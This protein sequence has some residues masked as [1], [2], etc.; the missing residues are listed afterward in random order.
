[1]NTNTKPTLS[2]VTATHNRLDLTQEYLESLRCSLAEIR[3]PY[4]LIFVDDASTDGTVAFLE[5]F[6]EPC[7]ILVNERN[8]GYAYS[9]NKGAR[10]AQGDFLCLLNNDLVLTPGW[11]QPMIQ[12]CRSDEGSGAIGNVQINIKSN[13]IE[14]AGVFFDLYGIPLHARKNRRKIPS[15]PTLEWPAVT[16]ACLLIRRRVFWEVGGFDE[17]YI[18]GSEDIDLC[19]KL[20]QA[21]YRNIVCNRSIIYH[22]VSSSPGSH[23]FKAKNLEIFLSKWQTMAAKIGREQWPTEYL[24]R[25]ARKWWRCNPRL[26]LKAIAMLATRH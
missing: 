24:Q 12:Q 26:A 14:H 19:L 1:M 17:A 7:T 15:P 25:Y 21:G 22:H 23:K 4:E 13:L 2:I 6:G 8:R 5:Q 16:A 20:V 11:L 10:L 3:D 18:N 9:N